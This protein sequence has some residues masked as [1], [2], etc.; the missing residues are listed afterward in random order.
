MAFLNS[1]IQLG[2]NGCGQ[3]AERNGAHNLPT[4]DKDGRG[5]SHA[6]F[7]SQFHIRLDRTLVG[8]RTHARAPFSHVCP[9]GGGVSRPYI[10]GRRTAGP[11][12]LSVEYEHTHLLLFV[13]SFNASCRFGGQRRNV[14]KREI[15]VMKFNFAL[16]FF[17]KLKQRTLR[18]SAMGS[19]KIEKLYH[20]H[21]AVW[22]F[23]R[24]DFAFPASPATHFHGSKS[25]GNYRGCH[26]EE[27]HGLVLFGS[28]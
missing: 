23:G 12:A 15:L 3:F 19:A 25:D 26:Q 7:F 14:S 21:P 1:S 5:G 27:S 17:L 2:P 20:D 16:E 11:L 6:H 24:R 18:G 13:V 22:R 4:S 28:P 10:L 9:G 8:P